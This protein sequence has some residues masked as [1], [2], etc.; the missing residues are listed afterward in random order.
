MSYILD[1]LKK[2]ESERNSGAASQPQA[3]LR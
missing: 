3:Q 2:A 1:A